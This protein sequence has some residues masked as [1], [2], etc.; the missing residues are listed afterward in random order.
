MKEFLQPIREKRKYY[1][2][3]LDEVKDIVHSGTAEA[4]KKAEATIKDVKRAMKL[5]N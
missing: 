2:E 4:K 1:E 5:D 3:H